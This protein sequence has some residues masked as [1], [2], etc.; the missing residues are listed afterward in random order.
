MRKNKNLLVVC[1]TITCCTIAL[2]FATSTHGQETIY[3]VR[4]QIA[5]PHGYAQIT[6]TSRLIDLIEHLTFQNQQI[7]QNRGTGVDVKQLNKKLDS[8]N[9]NLK[10][11]S[12]RI[13]KIEKAL[14][15]KTP[16]NI[17]EVL[18]KKD[19]SQKHGF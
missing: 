15:I 17:P 12:K 19:S 13:T 10:D 11:I 7:I 4:P 14:N 6:D 18:N 1:V 9:S 3:E 16:K 2:W 5:F 8:I